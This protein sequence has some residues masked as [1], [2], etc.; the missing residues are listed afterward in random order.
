MIS[1]QSYGTHPVTMDLSKVDPNHLVDNGTFNG[2]LEDYKNG[3]SFTIGANRINLTYLQY[4]YFVK[5]QVDFIKRLTDKSVSDLVDSMN[6]FIKQED[7]RIKEEKRAETEYMT[8]LRVYCLDLLGE[9]FDNIDPTKQ[10][11]VRRL[12][13]AEDKIEDLEKGG[14]K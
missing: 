8:K 3:V 2:P 13:K 12:M 10:E 11:L 9:K 14:K 1:I 6:C 5:V 4:L 7:E